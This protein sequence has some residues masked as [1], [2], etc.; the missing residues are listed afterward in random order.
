MSYDL[1]DVVTLSTTVRDSAGALAN[2]GNMALTITLP[3]ATTTSVPTVAPASTGTYTYAYPTVQAGRHTVRW[4]ATGANATAYADVFN[5]RPAAPPMLFSLAEAKAKLDI[6]ASSTS[7]DEELREF[8]EATT[9]AV[10]YF[11]GAVVRRT[12]QQVVQGGRDVWLLHTTP[13][14]AVTTVTALTS[15]QQA[16]DT[17]VL[18][19]D[20]STGVVRRTDGLCF[21]QGDYRITYTAGRALVPPHVSLAGKLILQHMWRTNYGASRGLAG[22]GGGDDVSVTEPIPGFGYA[23][24]NRALQLLQPDRDFGGFA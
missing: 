18:D 11:V 6:P 9:A 8:I 1:G 4:L 22:I 14:L 3:D 17:S 13:V 16:V 10:E 23:I 20:A 5:V 21:D 19:V 7:E 12:V 15:W 2:A 24:P